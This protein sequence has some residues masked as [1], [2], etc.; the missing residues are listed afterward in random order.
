MMI[1]KTAFQVQPDLEELQDTMEANDDQDSAK[2]DTKLG[3]LQ[4]K[5]DYD[6]NTNNVSL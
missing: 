3:R 4:Y 5:L 1:F 6:F 2:S